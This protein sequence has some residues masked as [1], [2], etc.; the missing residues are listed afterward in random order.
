MAPMVEG[1]A[2]EPNSDEDRCAPRSKDIRCYECG[3]LG[4]KKVSTRAA[5]DKRDKKGEPKPDALPDKR[6]YTTS[7]FA[8]LMEE[9]GDRTLTDNRNRGEIFIFMD[10]GAMV[11]LI[12]P[13]VGKEAMRACD[14]QARGVTGTQLDILREQQIQFGIKSHEEYVPFETL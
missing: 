7:R 4:H 2:S 6:P 1:M 8:S 12:Q 14:M 5:E 10:T 9:V 3:Q 13:T 11:S